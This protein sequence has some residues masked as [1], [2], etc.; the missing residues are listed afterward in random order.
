MAKLILCLFAV[1]LTCA[2]ACSQTNEQTFRIGIADAKL[3]NPKEVSIRYKSEL[4]PGQEV[5]LRYNRIESQLSLTVGDKQ[6]F[7]SDE[8][9]S[10]LSDAYIFS[11]ELEEFL[12]YSGRSEA[13]LKCQ[14]IAFAIDYSEDFSGGNFQ[15]CDLSKQRFRLRGTDTEGE[16]IIKYDSALSEQPQR[17]GYWN[18]I[19]WSPSQ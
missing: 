9:Y 2:T 4:Y 1:L 17:E 11:F 7:A 14:L 3:I 15:V 12:I 8:V 10:K 5:E 16:D 6:F 19:P 18:E 13:P